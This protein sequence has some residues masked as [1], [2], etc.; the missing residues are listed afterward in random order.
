MSEF[1]PYHQ[2]LGYCRSEGRLRILAR[3][4]TTGITTSRQYYL[5]ER[6]LS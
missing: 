4:Y 1:E 5:M 2:W 6:V 3:I